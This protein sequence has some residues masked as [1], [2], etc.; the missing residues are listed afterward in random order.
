MNFALA[1]FS[2]LKLWSVCTL[3][4]IL[5]CEQMVYDIGYLKNRKISIVMDVIW[6]LHCRQI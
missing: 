4:P 1:M 5:C 2:E 3:L 6:H